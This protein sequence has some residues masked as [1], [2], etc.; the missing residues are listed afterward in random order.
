MRSA[1][2]C[3]Y[4]LY[5]SVEHFNLSSRPTDCCY[6]WIV[7]F[8]PAEIPCPFCVYLSF[9]HWLAAKWNCLRGMI[10]NDLN[11]SDKID[12]Y[13]V[14]MLFYGAIIID[15]D[16]VRQL[17]TGQIVPRTNNTPSFLH[18]RTNSTPSICTSGQIVPHRF[19]HADKQY[20]IDFHMRTNSTPWFCTSGQIVPHRFSH[21]DKQYPIDF[22]MRTNSTPYFCT[23]GQTVPR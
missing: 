19:S 12:N 18:M 14:S 1:H 15:L 17:G 7:T 5:S 16:V 3:Y 20:P 6:Q 11:F 10:Q 21:A 4:L 22:H 13:K 9:L 23:G 8:W 2:L